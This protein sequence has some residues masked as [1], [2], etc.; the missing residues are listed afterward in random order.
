[1]VQVGVECGIEL[2]DRLVTAVGAGEF[3]AG[4]LGSRGVQKRPRRRLKH[5]RGSQQCLG[6]T[7]EYPAGVPGHPVNSGIAGRSRSSSSVAC[8]TRARK[9]ASPAA[10]ATRAPKI[11]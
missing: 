6:I 10:D 3:T 7:L 2:I 4:V 9:P 8:R 1:M 11:T 5:V